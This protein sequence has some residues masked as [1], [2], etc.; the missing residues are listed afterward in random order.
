MNFYTFLLSPHATILADSL[1]TA[2]AI[3]YTA[4]MPQLRGQGQPAFVLDRQLQ[5]E[6]GEG[7]RQG[8]PSGPASRNRARRSLR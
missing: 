1:D 7:V 5:S 3:D 8:L 2:R 4:H 6:F